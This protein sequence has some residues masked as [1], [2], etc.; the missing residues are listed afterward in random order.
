MDIDGRRTTS[1]IS[2]GVAEAT[3][4]DTHTTLIANAM[5]ALQASSAQQNK[6][7]VFS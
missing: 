6:V 4:T 3:R 7:T 5:Q 2:V 1:T